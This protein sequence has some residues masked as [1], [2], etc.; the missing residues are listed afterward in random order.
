V[1]SV[2]YQDTK[3]IFY[4]RKEARKE[5]KKAKRRD[6]IEEKRKNKNEKI[7]NKMKKLEGKR[8]ETVS[9]R[10]LGELTL[11]LESATGIQSGDL[12]TCATN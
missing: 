7:G 4:W 9:S 1:I 10:V 3:Y 11:A 2:Y 5:I 8:R 6:S 12:L